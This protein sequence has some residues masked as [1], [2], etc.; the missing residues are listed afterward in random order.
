[1]I[2]LSSLRKYPNIPNSLIT[3]S[4]EAYPFFKEKPYTGAGLILSIR[5]YSTLL[6][7]LLE[8]HLSSIG[9]LESCSK[10]S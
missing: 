4:N 6:C 1:M 2:D 9:I 7:Y 10:I 8:N 5:I 3:E